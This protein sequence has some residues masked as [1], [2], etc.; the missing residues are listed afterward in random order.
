MNSEGFIVI[1][2][3]FN[4]KERTKKKAH[5]LLLFSASCKMHH[6]SQKHINLPCTAQ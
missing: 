3:N 2:K 5:S 4:S 6:P 1:S